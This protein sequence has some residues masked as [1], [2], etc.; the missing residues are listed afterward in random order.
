MQP[1]FLPYVGYFQLIE[2]CDYFVVYDDIQF[3]KRGWINR[4]RLIDRAQIHL[5]VVG[6]E[7]TEGEEQRSLLMQ[8]TD[9]K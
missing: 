7:D 8:S 9:T 6:S 1:Y 3:T 4:N 2:K 5:H